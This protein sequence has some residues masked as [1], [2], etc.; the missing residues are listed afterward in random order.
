MSN[1]KSR[2][3]GKRGELDIMHKLG[4][5]AKRVGHSYIATPVDVQTKFAVYQ[6]RNKNISGNAIVEELLKLEKVAPQHHHFV[7]FKPQRGTW[8][9][10][11][12]LS[13]HV[14]DHGD[15]VKVPTSAE[16]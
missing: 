12:L 3:K 13:Q 15:K 11:E 6:V 1:G 5:S 2:A 9:I 16:T 10:A 4:G 14:G 8:L 7:V